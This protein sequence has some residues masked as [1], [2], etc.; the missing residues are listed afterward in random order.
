MKIKCRAEDFQVCELSAT[1]PSS[2]A[3][4]LYELRKESLG[5]LEA[6]QAIARRWNISIDRFSFAGLKDRHAATVQ[7]LTI[8]RGPRRNL[9]QSH[10][11]LVYLGQIPH[12]FGP[13]DIQGNEFRIMVRDLG[14]TAATRMAACL[15]EDSA[16]VA[17][18]YF[19]RQRFGSLGRSGEYVA[20]PWCHG[21]FQRALRLALADANPH[22][23][24]D[25]RDDKRVLQEHWGDWPECARQVREP[26]LRQ[27]MDF[28]VQHPTD[29]RR[30]FALIEVRVRRFYLAAFQSG[31][32]NEL[33]ARHLRTLCPPELL[34]DLVIED[35]QLPFLR[36]CDPETAT[37]LQSE[38]PLPSARLHLAG[39]SQSEWIEQTV[40]SFGLELRQMRVKY[41]R[42]SF[43]SKGSRAALFTPSD[44]V[45]HAAPD[46][47]YP[48]RH[49]LRV[50]FRLPRGCY[51]TVWLKAL[52]AHV[53]LPGPSEEE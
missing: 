1:S 23:R 2:G 48:G 9:T 16:V 34:V 40:R 21:D 19:D 43:F 31:V 24:S 44:V 8:E 4:A 49:S 26:R 50:Q 47:L 14:Q 13:E 3:F 6:V 15:S 39:E 7:G 35:R 30:A 10:L 51:A 32:W 52:A 5:T 38:L 28:L 41:P 33:L 22:D 29:F 36:G 25:Q 45:A 46:E 42:D 37:A 11:E 53:Q 18:N 27:I 20:L 17:P 12:P